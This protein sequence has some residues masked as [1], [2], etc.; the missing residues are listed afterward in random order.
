MPLGLHRFGSRTRRDLSLIGKA[1][2][3]AAAECT[4]CTMSGEYQRLGPF[5]R[6]IDRVEVVHSQFAGPA[7]SCHARKLRSLLYKGSLP[8]LTSGVVKSRLPNRNVIR[9]LSCNVSTGILTC[10]HSVDILCGLPILCLQSKAAARAERL[11]PHRQSPPSAVSV[12]MAH[13]H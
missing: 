8:R 2:I 10:Y 5:V 13:L 3:M 12:S 6:T 7:G 1:C 4:R 11:P 9:L